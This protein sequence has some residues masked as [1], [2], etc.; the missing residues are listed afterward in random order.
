[1][2]MSYKLKQKVPTIK[3]L[4]DPF[5]GLTKKIAGESFSIGRNEE[6]DFCIRDIFVSSNHCVIKRTEQGLFE[7][8]DKSSNG[9]WVNG[10]N[11]LKRNVLLKN[12]SVIGVGPVL[13]M[14]EFIYE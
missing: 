5:R 6:N 4:R 11:V 8:F 1:M 13:F 10:K 3:V 12:K 9:T 7:L 14:F 2:Y